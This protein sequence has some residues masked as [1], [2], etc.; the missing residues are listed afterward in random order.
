MPA[1]SDFGTELVSS[2]PLS[3]RPL[4]IHL[5]KGRLLTHTKQAER[6]LSGLAALPIHQHSTH[7]GSY[8][9]SNTPSAL[10]L[11]MMRPSLPQKGIASRTNIQYTNIGALHLIDLFPAHC[12]RHHGNV[13]LTPLM[14]AIGSSSLRCS[15]FA[16]HL[17]PTPEIG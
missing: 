6:L 15:F 2:L 4:S 10:Q 16:S 1:R 5:A 11:P 14:S 8:P 9:K 13:V 3:R 7:P 17:W 12:P